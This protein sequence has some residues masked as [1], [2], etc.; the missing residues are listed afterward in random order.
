MPTLVAMPMVCISADRP[1]TH[2]V[3]AATHHRLVGDRA[4]SASTIAVKANAM[5][6]TSLRELP[7][8]QEKVRLES[9]DRHDSQRSPIPDTVNSA[10]ELKRCNEKAA[11]E[12]R[13]QPD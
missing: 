2:P 8:E 5:N 3:N 11:P 9:D 13:R 1:A 6:G 7:I 4:E 12:K 10:Q